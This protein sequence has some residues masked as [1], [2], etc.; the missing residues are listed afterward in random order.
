MFSPLVHFDTQ[1]T[2]RS[3][4]AVKAAHEFCTWKLE[5]G[6]N[7]KKTAEELEQR[8]KQAHKYKE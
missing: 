6:L 2:Y 4:D 8:V 7:R 3:Y 1:F 5:T